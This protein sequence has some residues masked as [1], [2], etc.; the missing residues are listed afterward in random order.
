MIAQRRVGETQRALRIALGYAR[1]TISEMLGALERI[2]LVER[3]RST[4][5]RRTHVVRLTKRGL[6]VVSRAND[7]CINSGLVPLVVDKL[8]TFGVV[9]ADAFDAQEDFQGICSSIRNTFGD[10]AIWELYLWHHDEYLSALCGL[11]GI[12]NEFAL[13]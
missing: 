11:D 13:R 4:R 8:L 7:E 3:S 12:D 2:G 5:D 6:D 1:A 9:E 10:T